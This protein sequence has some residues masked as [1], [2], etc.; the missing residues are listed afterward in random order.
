MH[1][2]HNLVMKKGGNSN[3]MAVKNKTQRIAYNAQI[4]LS[5]DYDNEHIP[6]DKQNIAYVYIDSKY[7]INVLPTLYISLLVNDDLYDKITS[8]RATGEFTLTIKKYILESTTTAG[9]VI[10]K[11]KYSYV[12]SITTENYMHDLNNASPNQG[13]DHYRKMLIGLVSK[14]MVNKMRKSFNGVINNVNES[15]LVSLAL[16]GT[17]P[18]IERLTTNKNFDSILIP[19]LSTRYQLLKFVFEK[20]PFY[21][22]EFILFM[23]FN[24]TYLLSKTGKNTATNDGTP[25]SVIIDVG[26]ITGKDAFLEGMTQADDHYYIS[27]NP[28]N[29]RVMSDKA[30][31]MAM[32]NITVIDED[33]N[34]THLDIDYPDETK[35]LTKK[36]IFI[37]SNNPGLLKNQ[38]ELENTK[39][40]VSKD[41]IDGSVL[42]PNKLYSITNYQGNESYNG[43]YILES[44]EEVFIPQVNDFKMTVILNLKKVGKLNQSTE[45]K[46]KQNKY[47]KKENKAITQTGKR[48][49]TAAQK[50]LANVRKQK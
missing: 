13:R 28:T 1:K 24:R 17:K 10:L 5:F 32:D 33:N 18:V 50:N 9:K 25:D 40:S 49:T 11:D 48:S 44:K 2:F 36:E 39:V 26:E 19:P 20:A 12:P 3:I 31:S 34:V 15:T 46:N 14:T 35:G 30:A 43:S 29:F 8:N 23:D 45:S 22:T 42:T 27:I 38:L 16:E 21:D 4:T 7:E 41:Y 6:I 47:T 37:R